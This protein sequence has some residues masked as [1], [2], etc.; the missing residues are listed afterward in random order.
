MVKSKDRR[1]RVSNESEPIDSD[2][3]STDQNMKDNET[4]IDPLESIDALIEPTESESMDKKH[5]PTDDIDDENSSNAGDSA[6]VGLDIQPKI[7]LVPITSLLGQNVP[8]TPSID[9]NI[10]ELDS[11]D[12][13]SD[14][15]Q[16]LKQLVKP[17]NEINS[18][19]KE[20]HQS[21]ESN[22][23]KVVNNNASKPK[24]KKSYTN[25]INGHKPNKSDIVIPVQ[26]NVMVNLDP[27][28]KRMENA[29]KKFNLSEIRD[30]KS[31][32]VASSKV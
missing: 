3:N 4:D 8:K 12:S 32:V 31:R 2:D 13:N 5:D 28:P 17:S 21:I 7:R 15:D 19:T 9:S 23:S 11:D 27:L 6:C 30:H 1:K 20:R 10:I 24:S 22:E 25:K 29:L 16:P 26:F 14:D 18:K